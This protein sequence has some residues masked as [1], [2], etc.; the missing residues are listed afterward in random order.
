MLDFLQTSEGAVTAAC[1]YILIGFGWNLVYNSC[2]YL[3]LAI[4]EFYVLG[5]IL[6]VRIE[7]DLGIHSP[8]LAGPLMIL[9]LAS[10]G[11]VCELVL[12]RPV[13]SDGFRPLIVTLGLALV[14]LQVANKLSPAS[15]IRPDAFIGGAPLSLFGLLISPQE[16]IVWGTCVVVTVGLIA[17]FQRTDLGRSVR[18]SVDS[19]SGARMLGLKVS[20]YMTGAFA[21]GAGL[22]AL[23]SFVVAPTQGV[24][25]DS[26]DLIA[27]KSFMAVAIG[28]LGSYRGG[29]VGAL[30]VALLEAYLARY[31]NPAAQQIVILVVFLLV[32]YVQAVGTS[33]RP[34]EWR[35][36]RR[37]RARGPLLGEPAPGER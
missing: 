34:A 11:A 31:W 29:V 30:G 35:R 3:N 7:S 5:A 21:A 27:I 13:S 32:L 4:G 24:S 2:G 17:F 16:L 10:L 33:P 9:A 26:G 19:P 28:G 36:R 14:L 23:A 8:L 37:R 1:V 12:L 22:A 25:Y 6:A 20:W 15:V 18:A